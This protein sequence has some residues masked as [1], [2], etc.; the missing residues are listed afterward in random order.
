MQAVHNNNK[1]PGCV[2]FIGN[3][4]ACVSHFEM[5]SP[6][7]EKFIKKNTCTCTNNM[8]ENGLMYVY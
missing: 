7:Y 2:F 3:L 1:Y 6:I 8:L 4:M 5:K